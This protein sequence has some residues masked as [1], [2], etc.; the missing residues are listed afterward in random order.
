MAEK[1]EILFQATKCVGKVVLPPNQAEDCV[2][3]AKMA[4]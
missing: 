2:L 3:V 4:G 1:K